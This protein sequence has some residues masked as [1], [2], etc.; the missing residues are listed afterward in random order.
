M[1]GEAKKFIVVVLL[2]LIKFY[3]P[4]FDNVGI[5]KPAV[6]DWTY[7][8]QKLTSLVVRLTLEG[9][10]FK[11]VQAICQYDTLA[12]EKALR[13]KYKQLQGKL[14]LQDLGVNPLL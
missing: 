11:I 12:D 7:F 4:C 5:S 1:V 6:L 2:T 13:I 9:S 14:K 8:Q 10:V 3:E